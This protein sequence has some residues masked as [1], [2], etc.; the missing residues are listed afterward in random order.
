ME[1]QPIEVRLG[2]FAGLPI[3]GVYDFKG[4][5]IQPFVTGPGIPMTILNLDKVLRSTSP[6]FIIHIGIAGGKKGSLELGQVVQVSTDFFGDIGAEDR[7]GQFI[8]MFQLGLIEENEHPWIEGKL[9]NPFHWSNS[10]TRPT[11]GVTIN[12]IPGT[13]ESQLE[14][15]RR[16]AFDIESMEG[17]ALFYVALTNAIPFC[18]LRSIS[19]FIEPRNRENWELDLATDNLSKSCFSLIETLVNT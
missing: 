8:N 7:S 1:M 10:K 6:D 9:V 14:M 5:K 17:A 3:R 4:V 12:C 11:A 15:T 13:M 16:G 2:M 19:N 18:S